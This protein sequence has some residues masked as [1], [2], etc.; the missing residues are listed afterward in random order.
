MKNII[1]LLGTIA[2]AMLIGFSFAACDTDEKLEDLTGTIE[3][4]AADDSG[5]FTGKAYTAQLV[6][7]NVTADLLEWAWYK[8]Q[9]MEYSPGANTQTYTPTSAGEYTVKA[10]SVGIDGIKDAEISAEI[11]IYGVPQY[12]Y[13][14]GTWKMVG[15]DNNNWKPTPAPAGTVTDETMVIK[16]VDENNTSFRLDST[17]DDE[18]LQFTITTWE[19]FTGAQIPGYQEIYKLTYTDATSKEYKTT[20]TYYLARKTQGT[21][22]K[23]I[24]D[25]WFQTNASAG[26]EKH[27]NGNGQAR[28]Y[29]KQ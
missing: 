18:F 29:V 20:Y 22:A 23:P 3:I 21:P 8:G 28:S 27:E 9:A 12:N 7:S 6:N 10:K 11:K 13:M 4:K 25:L 1:K 15:A 17:Y 24:I 14:L 5:P 16:W 19:R 26:Y 2:M